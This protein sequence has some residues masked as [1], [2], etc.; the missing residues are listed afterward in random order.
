[1]LR[2]RRHGSSDSH[3]ESWRSRNVQTAPECLPSVMSGHTW[4][5]PPSRRACCRRTVA[6][7][8]NPS[9]PDHRA[10]WQSPPN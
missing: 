4:T 7:H 6:S 8:R 2:A 9:Q 5:A 10:N 1:M 3:C